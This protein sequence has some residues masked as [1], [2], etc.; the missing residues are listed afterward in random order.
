M[1]DME[2]D[3]AD[4]MPIPTMARCMGAHASINEDCNEIGKAMASRQ[5]TRDTAAAILAPAVRNNSNGHRLREEKAYAQL[6]V[7]ERKTKN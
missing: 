5:L 2:D 4:D 7:D 1:L 3:D 6:T